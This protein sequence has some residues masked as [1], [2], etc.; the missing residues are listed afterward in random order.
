MLIAE[1]FLLLHFQKN[2][3]DFDA[4]SNSDLSEIILPQLSVIAE[5]LKLVFVTK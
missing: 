4:I 1:E 2:N 5:N 3:T